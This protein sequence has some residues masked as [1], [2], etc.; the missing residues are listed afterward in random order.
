MQDKKNL[1]G[2]EIQRMKAWGYMWVLR[3]L[4]LCKLSSTQL[5]GQK[6]GLK[7]WK[8]LRLPE[9][10]LV[11]LWVLNFIPILEIVHKANEKSLNCPPE[12]KRSDQFKNNS[13]DSLFF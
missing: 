3:A 1:K 13:T 12:T 6:R 4:V 8:V 11:L 2:K 7:C 10:K 5:E 9:E